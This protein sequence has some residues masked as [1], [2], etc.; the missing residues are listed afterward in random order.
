MTK[1]TTVTICMSQRR[2]QL[3]IDQ[4]KSKHVFIE[5]EGTIYQWVSPRWRKLKKYISIYGRKKVKLLD[6]LDGFF[7]EIAE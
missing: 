1:E 3:I 5:L 2:A 4:Y 6:P 7:Y